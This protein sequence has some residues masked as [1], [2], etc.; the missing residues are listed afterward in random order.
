MTD[1]NNYIKIEGSVG[2]YVD[3]TFVE[4][5]RKV[6]YVNAFENLIFTNIYEYDS[7]NNLKKEIH[8]T[9]YLE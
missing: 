5:G 1:E 8:Y 4:E 2:S 7:L 3:S 6:K 9:K